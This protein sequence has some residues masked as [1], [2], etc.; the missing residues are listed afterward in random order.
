M[1]S[2]FVGRRAELGRLASVCSKSITEELPA[3]ALVSGPPG[4]GKSR[5]L[6]ELVVRQPSLR[7][8]R[9]AG[10]EAG[11]QVPLAASA[12]MLR[13]L[14]YVPDAGELVSE[15]LFPPKSDTHRSLE[16]LRVLE[17]ARQALLGID[18]PVVLLVDD[19]QWIDDLSIALCSY[20]VRAAATE[21]KKLAVVAASRPS[22]SAMVFRDSLIAELGTD[23]VEYID[24]GPLDQDDAFDL[25]MQ[26]APER[27]AEQVAEIRA[28]AKGSPFWLGMLA[29][30]GEK[31]EVADY[32]AAWHKGLSG[33]AAGLLGLLAVATRPLGTPE[34]T[35]VLGWDRPRC[36]R[37][38]IEL[39]RS[40]LVTH[41]GQ[42]TAIAH[43]LIRGSVITEMSAVGRRELH[44]ALAIWL[45]REAETDVQ[46]LSESLIHRREAGMDLAGLALRVLGSPRRRLLG[47]AVLAELAQV[48]ESGEVGE[49]VEVALRVSVA[50][51]AGE[52]G[53]QQIALDHWS[54]L[55]DEVADP[56]LRATA[57]LAASR[58]AM[59]IVDRKQD[60]FPLLE[61]AQQLSTDDAVLAVEI[62]SHRANLLQVVI[63][64]AEDGRRAAFGAAARARALWGEPPIELPERERDAY[65]AALQVAFD[66]AVV[67]EDGT[68]QL[69]LADELTRVA[70]GSEEGYVWAAQDRAT[71]FMFAG[72]TAEAIES[73]QRAWTRARERMLPMLVLTSG[74]SLTSKLL[75][76]GRLAEADEVISECLELERR[77]A[78]S[79]ERFAM[80][81]VGDFSIHSVRHELWLSRGDWRDAIASLEREI[82]RQ[83]D[84]HFRMHLHWHVFV[85][86]ARCADRNRTGQIDHHVAASR[87]DARAA[88]CLRCS[89]EL[90]LRTAE[91]FARLGRLREAETQLVMWDEAGRP[92][93]AHH[94]LWRRQVGAL[95]AVA[96]GD[97]SGVA[98]L[99]SVLTATTERGLVRSALWTRLDFAA[100]LQAADN[101]RAA[102]EFRLAGELAAQMGATTEQQLAE[103]GLRRLGVRTWRRTRAP[104]GE[105]VLD[106]LS[107]REKQIAALIAA[108][109]SNPEIAG[110]LFLSRKTIERHISNIL[111]RTGTRN[112]TELA[113]VLS[114]QELSS[115]TT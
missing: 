34:C 44:A 115:A 69:R 94:G 6:S 46:L 98:E 99:D 78:G 49:P 62:E 23:R 58:A 103:L 68:T 59:H 66:A 55:A 37:A 60:A 18:D 109:H 86:L 33:D 95:L 13:E 26:L 38:V 1:S 89:R 91:T 71:A 28:R 101:R 19:V 48:A 51:L 8:L 106:R 16:P 11:A 17:A 63:R 87:E 36:E 111:A 104:R 114:A 5:L 61:R 27:S 45:E 14:G 92:A 88:G 73:A 64:Q 105:R 43:D 80:G 85:W 29:R 96:S 41:L 39:E 108:G 3:A 42:S 21:Q 15:L 56:T 112:R 72:R 35:G 47:R 54:A 50:Q 53:E 107:A 83:G 79:T 100:V 110:R 67:E 75:E 77:V 20:L 102:E 74:S 82:M 22:T 9:V 4:S 113:R 65:I 30:V 10:F 81:R 24:L 57:Y 31:S 7:R 25:V 97:S 52:L 40:G 70:R 76:A 90:A 2:T 84:P 32:L 12:D 93:S